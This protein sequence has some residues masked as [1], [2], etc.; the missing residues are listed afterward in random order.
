MSPEI[1]DFI[2]FAPV[3]AKGSGLELFW[4][5]YQGRRRFQKLR[6]MKYVSAMSMA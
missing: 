4:Q 6:S 1:F 5:L 3:G 2:C